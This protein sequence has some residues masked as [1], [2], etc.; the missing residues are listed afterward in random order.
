MTMQLSK[1]L[2]QFVLDAVRSGLYPSEND[3]IR[4]ALIR[5]K[6]SLPEEKR[7]PAQKAKRAKSAKPKQKALTRAE[8][9]QHLLAIGLLRVRPETSSA[10]SRTT[11]ADDR[12]GQVDEG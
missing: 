3:V 6:Q 10:F 12:I 2:E 5:L 1:D 8:F 4:D 9:D 7:T 11:V